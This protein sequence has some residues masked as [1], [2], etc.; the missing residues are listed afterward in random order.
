MGKQ[1]ER[2]EV[3]GLTKAS[4]FATGKVHLIGPSAAVGYSSLFCTGRGIALMMPEPAGAEVTC[5]ACAK[6]A[7]KEG[8]EI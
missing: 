1:T 8:V 5:A 2:I 7:R 3:T 4:T 6:K